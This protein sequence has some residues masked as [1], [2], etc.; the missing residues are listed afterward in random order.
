MIRQFRWPN[1]VRDPLLPSRLLKLMRQLYLL[2][3]QRGLIAKMGRKA[4]ELQ[5]HS[6]SVK[7]CRRLPIVTTAFLPRPTW[8]PRFLGA[9]N[10]PFYFRG[11]PRLGFFGVYAR[12]FI[13]I[14][15]GI[16]RRDTWF[17]MRPPASEPGNLTTSVWRRH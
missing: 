14:R 8:L 1:N 3:F 7:L 12:A 16:I 11:R 17:S 9:D 6:N 10:W 4:K 13:F 2:R 5:R 15:S